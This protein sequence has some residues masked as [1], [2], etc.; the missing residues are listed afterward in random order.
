[1][2]ELDELLAEEFDAFMEEERVD[3][4]STPPSKKGSVFEGVFDVGSDESDGRMSLLSSLGMSRGR[5]LE[6]STFRF[7]DEPSRP[8]NRRLHPHQVH[9]CIHQKLPAR[10]RVVCCEEA[11]RSKGHRG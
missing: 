10:H 3:L 8:Q 7:A 11:R 9:H 5:R 2:D 4:P 6:R 1:L